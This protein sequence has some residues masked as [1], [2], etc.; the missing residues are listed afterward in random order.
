M[1]V[2]ITKTGTSS[3][4]GKVF[5]AVPLGERNGEAVRIK[6]KT[7][8]HTG[9]SNYYYLDKL[10]EDRWQ[11]VSTE[12]IFAE[13]LVGLDIAIT[14]TFETLAGCGRHKHLVD[15]RD[16]LSALDQEETEDLINSIYEQE[17]Q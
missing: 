1:I 2:R 5:A 15:L 9:V 16:E 14:F 6:V 17:N 4:E 7:A 10:W 8:G 12:D 11:V 13:V 3:L